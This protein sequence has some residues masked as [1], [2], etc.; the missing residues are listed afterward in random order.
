M[1]LAAL[2]I[3][4]LMKPKYSTEIVILYES[5]L[6][7]MW[8]LFETSEIIFLF[9][10]G[11]IKYLKFI[12]N[13]YRKICSVNKFMMLQQRGYCNGYSEIVV[14]A[15][16]WK[17]HCIQMHNMWYSTSGSKTDLNTLQATEKK[18]VS[19]TTRTIKTEALIEKIWITSLEKT[20]NK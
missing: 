13:R 19:T 8:H 6:I 12:I 1:A 16:Q 10:E 4:R 2:M 11:K 5:F 18:S 7:S 20:F 14:K 15:Q 9:W 3:Q 17:E